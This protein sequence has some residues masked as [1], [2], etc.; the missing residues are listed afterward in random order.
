MPF[1]LAKKTQMIFAALVKKQRWQAY[2]PW[3][4]ADERFERAS[5]AHAQIM[6]FLFKSIVISWRLMC[7]RME[8]CRRSRMSHNLIIWPESKQQIFV[9]FGLRC[10]CWCSA[11]SQL[12]ICV[13]I[14][15]VRFVFVCLVLF[16]WLCLHHKTKKSISLW[17]IRQI[18]RERHVSQCQREL[19]YVFFQSSDIPHCMS[20]LSS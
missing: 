11:K 17:F 14:A 8:R 13:C 18:R 4:T 10:C 1:R 5:D 12:M 19:L 7:F 16:L 6:S 2:E 9:V 3:L 20:W 15:R